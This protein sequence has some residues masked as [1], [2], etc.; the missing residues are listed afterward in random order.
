VSG[1]TPLIPLYFRLGGFACSRYWV[2]TFIHRGV[3][4]Q[5]GL[6]NQL[7]FPSGSKQPLA[8]STDDSA[9]D[10]SSGARTSEAAH[11]R[12]VVPLVATPAQDA[13]GVILK[14]Q[15]D[16]KGAAGAA[17]PGDLVYSNGRKGAAATDADTDAA[18]M[19]AEHSQALQRSAASATQL[20]VDKE[21]VLVAKPA[22]AAKGQDFVS[23]AVS[24]MRDY[25]DE[26]ERLKSANPGPS[27]GSANTLLPR[28][29]AEVQK[30]AARFKLFA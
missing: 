19:Q 27:G 8:G 4:M 12:K 14:I 25:A 22:A 21:G 2:K 28:G 13:S 29:L 10:A 3:A 23:F 9:Q 7:S 30:L 18:R 15:A 11:A 16:A 1:N 24:A 5:I 20:S 17:L 26:Q 6:L